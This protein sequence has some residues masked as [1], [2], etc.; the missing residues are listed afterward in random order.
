MKDIKFFRLHKLV[1]LLAVQI[2]VILACNNPGADPADLAPND[3]S[4]KDFSG[5]AIGSYDLSGKNLQNTDFSFTDIYNVNFTG[6]DLRGANFTEARIETS[7]FTDADLR[8]TIFDR[9]CY[10]EESIW[11]QAKMDPKWKQVVS[12]FDDGRLVTKD[13]RGLDLSRVC[14][15]V[16]L[17]GV[18]FSE[19][20]LEEA[21][22]IGE[23]PDVLFQNAN[24]RHAELTSNHFAGVDFT[25]ADVTGVYFY[26]TS[27]IGA[28]ISEAQLQ[29]AMVECSW[30]PDGRFYQEGDCLVATPVP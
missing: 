9:A 5:L 19:A 29:T 23:L 14:I 25:G 10:F 18:D 24:L 6:A 3:L 13:L 21:I 16:D 1:I 12:L 8:G 26:N 27:L 15:T 17:S 4:G 11:T 2:G 7:N 20:N 30:L 28:T 22:L